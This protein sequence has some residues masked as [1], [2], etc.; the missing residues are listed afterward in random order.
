MY[1]CPSIH[2]PLLVLFDV[3]FFYVILYYAC[4][5]CFKR[6]DDMK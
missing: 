2:V 6:Y 3:S 5:Y 1:I 4:V